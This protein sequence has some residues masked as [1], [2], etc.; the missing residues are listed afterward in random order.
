MNFYLI[1]LTALEYSG[2]NGP[3]SWGGL[4]N[5]GRSQTPIDIVSSEA[6]VDRSLS[7]LKVDYSSR[8]RATITNSAVNLELEVSQTFLCSSQCHL[9]VRSNN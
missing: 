9:L 3:Q 4:C 1:L 2:P 7:V 6:V 5:I 8:T